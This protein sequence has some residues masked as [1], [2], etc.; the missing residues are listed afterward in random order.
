M[1]VTDGFDG[2]VRDTV[3]G[4]LLRGFVWLVMLFVLTP[5]IVICTMAFTAGEFL[6]F[7][8][9][10]FSLRWFEALLADSSWLE[11][12]STSV[13]VGI[14]EPPRRTRWTATMPAS[15]RRWQRPRRCRLCCR[16]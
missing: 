5:L 12:I 4:L 1:S 11:A 10:G 13:M 2:N 15:A 14:P 6:T 8:P 9:E 16:R 3:G 7:P